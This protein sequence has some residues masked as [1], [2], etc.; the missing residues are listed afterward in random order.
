MSPA[1][2]VSIQQRTVSPT[3][4]TGCLFVQQR[5]RCSN[6]RVDPLKRSPRHLWRQRDRRLDKL[7]RRPQRRRL[8]RGH[9]RLAGP[10]LD[11]PALLRCPR[12]A[13]ESLCVVSQQQGAPPSASLWQAVSHGLPGPTRH[14]MRTPA[15]LATRWLAGCAPRGCCPGPRPGSRPA[16]RPAPRRCAGT[17]HH[18]T[19][20]QTAAAIPAASATTLAS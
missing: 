1:S 18:R 6:Q 15:T 9:H 11:L 17:R 4:P 3:S 13:F 19:A 2:S 8:Q 16:R 10:R 14:S 5:L 7:W 20:R 12:S